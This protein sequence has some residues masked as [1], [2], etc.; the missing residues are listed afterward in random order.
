[1][2]GFIVFFV[3]L[4][5]ATASVDWDYRNPENWG[6]VSEICKSGKH[7]SPINIK[8]AFWS[9]LR[10]PDFE[11][12]YTSIEGKWSHGVRKFTPKEKNYLFL[13][14]N[15][16]TLLQFHFHSRSEHHFKGRSFPLE[17]HYVHVDDNGDLAVIAVLFDF[18]DHNPLLDKL[19]DGDRIN[20]KDL[21]PRIPS[22]YR[23]SGSLTT[24]PCS[25]G[26]IWYIFR[27]TQEIS[28]HQLK[29]FLNPD[30]GISHRPL[31]NLHARLV[32]KI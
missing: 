25:E 11:Y 27:E 12:K 17:A 19:L 10:G 18:G 3:F 1:V 9:E 23:Y 21:M 30:G 14:G 28:M 4:S 7:Q 29:D 20:P 31:Q 13:E 6:E 5:T 2:K 8:E 26:L 24:P 32:L 15:K 16:Y 22:Y